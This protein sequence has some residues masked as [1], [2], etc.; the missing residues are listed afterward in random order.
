MRDAAG[1]EK[2]VQHC[3]AG[4]WEH[5]GRGGLCAGGKTTN[6]L[7]R[8]YTWRHGVGGDGILP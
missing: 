2:P 4:E 8:R 5:C 1:I 3:F 6:M 7:L